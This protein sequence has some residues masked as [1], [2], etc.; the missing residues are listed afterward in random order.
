MLSRYPKR[1]LWGLIKS[2]AGI[3]TTQEESIS[4]RSGLKAKI[5]GMYENMVF[6]GVIRNMSVHDVCLAEHRREFGEQGKVLPKV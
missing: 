3:R 4:Q 5:T 2:N 6:R 1:C